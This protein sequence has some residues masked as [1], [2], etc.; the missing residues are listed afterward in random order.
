MLFF[1]LFCVFLQSNKKI[2]IA[3]HNMVSY[4]ISPRDGKLLQE[5]RD[6]DGEHGAGDKM[7][8]VG[9]VF[10]KIRQIL[11]ENNVLKFAITKKNIQMLFLMR[12][13][14][15]LDVVV[16]VCGR[17]INIETSNLAINSGEPMVWWR[18]LGTGS[19]QAH[20]KFDQRNSRTRR[21]K[22]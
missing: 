18:S 20:C 11:A 14:K 8:A 4:R 9:C 7:V 5:D 2:A 17:S 22:A 12:T 10:Q 15:V 13:M 3:T 1:L 21:C 16:V 19:F 6:D